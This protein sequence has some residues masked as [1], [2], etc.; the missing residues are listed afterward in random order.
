MTLDRLT[1]QSLLQEAARHYED[2]PALAYVDDKPISYTKVEQAACGL[3]ARL[4][5]LGIEKGDRVALLAE[6]MPNWGVA[7]FAVAAAGAVVVPVLPDFTPEDVSRIIEHSGS[8][9]VF[10]SD[11]MKAKVTGA[12]GM[13][14]QVISMNDEDFIEGASAEGISPDRIVEPDDLAA[15]IYTSGTTGSP[16]GVMLSHRNITSNVVA[17]APIPQMKERERLLSILPLSHTYECT[18]GLLVPFSLGACVYYIKKPPTPNVL[19]EALQKVKPGVMLSVPLLIEKIYRQNVKPSLTKSAAVRAL[20][21]I[22]PFRKLLH[23][24]AGKSLMNFFGGR[25]YFFGVGGAPLAPDVEHFLREARFPYAI[26][27]GLTETSPLIAGDNARNSRFTSTGRV[28]EGVEVKLLNPDP[29]TGEGEII[30]KGPNVMKGYYKDPEKTAEVF[31]E[32][33]WFRTGDLAV[34]NSKGYLY[35]KGRSKNVILGPSGENVYPET[36]ESLIN[37]FPYVQDSL[38]FAYEGSI[39]ARVHLDYEAIE[40]QV[41]ALKKSARDAAEY[42]KDHL[43]EIRKEANQKLSHFSRLNIIVEQKQPFE[44]TP[45]KK[46]K[47]F[48]YTKPDTETEAPAE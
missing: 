44:K 2:A 39:V 8:K 31:T 30:V 43:A 40:K 22:P 5:G 3:A 19:K 12:E 23:R 1:L 26:G 45:T 42:V 37:S 24:L 38:V 11:K 7:Y 47:R 33:G 28:L 10:V 4:Q 6:N 32:D 46:I 16:K 14:I 29:E 36:I 27:Y 41:E 15:I 13:G 48:L 21:K 18:I 20:S 34:M 25:I 17:A 9:A 35:I